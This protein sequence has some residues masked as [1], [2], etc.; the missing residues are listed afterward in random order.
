ML[1]KIFNRNNHPFE[2]FRFAGDNPTNYGTIRTEQ[3]DND[4][5]KIRVDMLSRGV[6][7]TDKLFPS[8]HAVVEDVRATLQLNCTM[9]CYVYNDATIQA[10]CISINQ[11]ND[12]VILV[13]SGLINIMNER[14]LKFVI[15]HE[16]GHLIFG[17]HAYPKSNHED[18][19]IIALNLLH[20]NRAAE[21]SAD[22]IGFLCTDNETD[23]TRAIV[24]TACGLN[25]EYIHADVSS[26]VDQLK[27]IVDAAGR[28]E[29][30]YETH[31][32]L[33]LRAKALELFAQGRP[34]IEWKHKRRDGTAANEVD[35]EIQNVLSAATGSR[36]E[37]INDDTARDAMQW[38]LIRLF[39]LDN[40]LSKDEQDALKV[41]L[42]KQRA[43]KIIEFLR[44]HGPEGFERK[45]NEA[46]E[47]MAT[48]PLDMRTRLIY[49]LEKYASASNDAPGPI[50]KE[51]QGIAKK[52]HVEHQVR[53]RPWQI[54]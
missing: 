11:G 15:G 37:E 35:S 14:E 49:D 19:G 6:R 33:P 46:I 5:Q 4:Y 1:D 7:I 53:L 13:S 34:F 39:M 41:L 40:R 28:S 26:Y 25:D 17:H 10:S 24:K 20:L 44:E 36:L 51:L 30:I 23:A 16:I 12:A 3:A 8:L 32:M 9:D 31:P 2:A 52:L 48:L 27:E 21:I 47:R 50:T 42:G 43:N 22:R 45:F 29:N 18:S 38:S 54:H